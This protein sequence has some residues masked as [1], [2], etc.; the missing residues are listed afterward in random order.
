MKKGNRNIN[1]VIRFVI[2][3]EV[4]EKNHLKRIF[5]KWQNHV[6]TL[7]HVSTLNHVSTLPINLNEFII[8]LFLV[9]FIFH[10]AIQEKQK[11]DCS[12]NLMNIKIRVE[13]K[14]TFRAQM[15]PNTFFLSMFAK[16]LQY[17]YF[18]HFNS[19]MSGANVLTQLYYTHLYRIQDY[20]WIVCCY[21]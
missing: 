5:K 17:Y 19:S 16:T 1:I 13:S 2:F 10:L 4:P 18:N 20:V 8:Y 15:Y 21:L 14:T 9:N 7:S 12:F 3:I 6:S 11:Y